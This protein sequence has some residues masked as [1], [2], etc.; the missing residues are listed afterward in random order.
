MDI[1]GFRK[2]CID[3]KF[4]KQ[5]I[6]TSIQSIQNFNT[7]LQKSKKGI[8]S[9]S[10]EDF[11][12][13]STHL[14]ST[15]TNTPDNY[16][17]ILRY[18]YYKKKNALIIAAMEVLDGSEVIENFSQRLTDEFNTDVRNRIFEGTGIPP[19][20]LHPSKKPKYMKE[21]VQRLINEIGTAVCAQFLNKGLRDKYEEWRQPDRE[22][23][24]KSEDID[25]FLEDR[26][27]RFIGELEKHCQEHTLFFTQEI[28]ED[29]LEYIKNDPHIETGVRQG[30]MIIITKIPHMAKEY[31]HEIEEPKK[32]YFYCHCPWVKEAFKE[33]NK[34]ISHVFCNCSAGYYKAYWEIVLDQPVEVEVLESLLTGAQCCRFAVR[35]P[36]DVVPA[37]GD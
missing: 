28:T 23:Y 10:Y 32:R 1:A 31:L 26:R 25:A 20:G 12:D 36:E 34:P 15:R 5:V 22:K 14:I 6:E 35:L 16:L 24:L 3:R 29:V 33:S 21:I 27:E 7:F 19:L 4:D 13:Y 37:K 8:D 2:Y 30:N 17:G 9:A 11:Y 18:G